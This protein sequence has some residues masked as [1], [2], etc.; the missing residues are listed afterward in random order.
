MLSLSLLWLLAAIAL[1]VVEGLTF[2][3]VTIWFAIG[4]AAALIVSLFTSSFQVQF[5]VFVAVSFVCLLAFRPLAAKLKS[6]PEATNGDRNLGRTA[7][8]LTPLSPD[9]TGR[10]RLDGVDWNA[11]TVGGATLQPGQ[12]CQVVDI[13]STLLFVEP[14]EPAAS[15][16]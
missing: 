6:P 16:A 8:V 14:Q 9:A 15:R 1:V 11:R 13:Q 5:L 7:T 2:N 4:S 10:V 3:L 12:A